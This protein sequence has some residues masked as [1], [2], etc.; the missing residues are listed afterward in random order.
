MSLYIVSVNSDTK[1]ST[2]TEDTIAQILE[3]LNMSTFLQ[4]IN[5]N[6]S[7]MDF[8]K[9]IISITTDA[10]YN[11]T[12]EYSDAFVAFDVDEKMP[13]NNN[14]SESYTKKN[15]FLFKAPYDKLTLPPQFDDNSDKLID[16]TED[17]KLV[18]PAGDN[19]FSNLYGFIFKDEDEQEDNLKPVKKTPTKEPQIVDIPTTTEQSAPLT[20]KKNETGSNNTIPLKLIGILHNTKKE[21]PTKPPIPQRKNNKII[22]PTGESLY[23][24]TDAPISTTTALPF[25][26]PKNLTDKTEN[27]SILR[28]VLLATFNHQSSIDRSNEILSQ[29]PLFL[30][31]PNNSISPSFLSGNIFPAL[32]T[33][34]SIESR[35]SFHQN[36]IRSELDLIIPDLNKNQASNDVGVNN[37]SPGSYHVLRNEPSTITHTDSYVVNP[38]D[39]SKL[40][41]HQSINSETKVY[42]PPSKDPAG[43]LKLA[44]CNIYGRM[45]SVGQI[46]N[47]L[48]RSCLECRCTEVGVSC[49]PVNC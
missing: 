18:G 10:N 2:T 42:T 5:S 44:G 24:N 36:P 43:L 45:Y 40:K 13:K 30:H 46:I 12:P 28:D 38:V 47:E 33:S 9:H 39:L 3:S 32:P 27:L 4:N 22:D 14:E 21:G 37:Y 48:S 26:I 41:A 19:F 35:N 15:E 16:K 23:E 7:M 8:E 17:E 34:N 1:V 20:N 25:E 6:Q 11:A 49:S 31:R 29:R